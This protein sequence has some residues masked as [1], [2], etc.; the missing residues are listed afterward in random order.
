VINEFDGLDPLY[1]TTI[2]GNGEVKSPPL[3]G[4]EIVHCFGF[5]VDMLATDLFVLVLM[6]G[7]CVALIFLLLRFVVKSAK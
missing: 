3:T 2:L 6:F 5:S 1:I 4:D 7:A